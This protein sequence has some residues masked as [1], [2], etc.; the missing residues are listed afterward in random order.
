MNILLKSENISY[1]APS[2]ELFNKNKTTEI[3]KNI[4]FELFENEILGIAGASGSGKTTLAKILAG[5]HS[6]YDGKLEF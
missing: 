3:L 1:N 5:V 6:L 4:S 2:N